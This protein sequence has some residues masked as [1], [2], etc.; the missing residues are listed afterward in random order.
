MHFTIA[1]VIAL[2]ASAVS[3]Y[4]HG[5]DMQAERDFITKNNVK[6]VEYGEEVIKALPKE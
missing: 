5:L 6:Y 1:L 2:T 3:A 4:N